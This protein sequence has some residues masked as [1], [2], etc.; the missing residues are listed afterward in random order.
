[1]TL[2]N[3]FDCFDLSGDSRC[4]EPRPPFVVAGRWLLSMSSLLGSTNI[5]HRGGL[6]LLGLCIHICC[7][8]GVVALS[9]CDATNFY[10][11]SACC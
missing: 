11:V 7:I 1:M 4:S 5:H 6:V 8:V 10:E 9:F 2:N 3:H